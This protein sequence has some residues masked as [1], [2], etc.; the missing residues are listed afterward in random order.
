M[1]HRQ[2]AKA[3]GKDAKTHEPR[4]ATAQVAITLHKR[5]QREWAPRAHGSI[6]KTVPKRVDFRW[7]RSGRGAHAS[8]VR[9]EPSRAEGLARGLQKWASKGAAARREPASQRV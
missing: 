6:V 5:G 2:R 7:V 8:A 4:N 9:S 1:T 3:A